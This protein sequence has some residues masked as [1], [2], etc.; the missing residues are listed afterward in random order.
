MKSFKTSL[1]HV[2]GLKY[3]YEDLQLLSP[4][5][6]KRLLHQTFI[7]DVPSLQKELD[8]LEE[9]ISFLQQ[10]SNVSVIESVNHIL[11][12]INDISST[13]TRLSKKQVLDDIELFEIK[14]FCLLAQQIANLLHSSE[15]HTISLTDSEPV[16]ELLDPE[17]T[18]IPHFYIYSAYDRVLE[19]LRKKMIS[20]SDP[21]ENEKYRWESVKREDLIRKNLSG[22][23]LPFQELLEHNLEQISILDVL[24]SKATQAI[25]L[26]FCKP[27]ISCE[28]T[29]Y[30][31]LFNP[32]IKEILKAD[33]K[34][35]QAV[36]IE[37]H[38]DC[39][40]ITGANMSGKTVL[41]KTLALAQYLVQFGFYVPATAASIAVMDDVAIVMGDQHSE[42]TGLSSFADEI[43]KTNQ[44]IEQVK[45]GKKLLVL[46]DELARSTNPE[47]GKALVSAF[48]RIMSD[49]KVMSL[50]TSHYS[51]IVSTRKLRVKGLKMET[52][53]PNITPQTLND[54]I[55]YSLVETQNDDVP[56]E[57][58]KIAE[59]FNID[60][61]FLQLAKEIM[62]GN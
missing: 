24:W 59:I 50:V 37:L 56:M 9:S 57:A 25:R 12:Q 61:E 44:I 31:Q 42:L 5:G 4:I 22:K 43:L 2:N 15:Y 36:D 11:Q 30:K 8:L 17:H 32:A 18:R 7:T 14:K 35:F 6:R 46:I 60:K 23:L 52:I 10:K 62:I 1:Q 53:T 54:H 49:Y 29:H 21:E 13:I 40:L 34:E 41:L 38:S 48:I 33:H 47:E 20:T 27:S 51:G 16:I 26:G 45:K 3:I 58:L 55:D 19:E 28:K 39:C